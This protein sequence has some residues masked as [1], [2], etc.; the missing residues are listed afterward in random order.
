MMCAI[1]LD[2]EA[3]PFLSDDAGMTAIHWAS[4]AGDAQVLQFLLVRCSEKLT[5]SLLKPIATG[6]PLKEIVAI[7]DS[8]EASAKAF[9]EGGRPGMRQHVLAVTTPLQSHGTKC[10]PWSKYSP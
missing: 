2:V 1:L 9:A 4:Q 7:M 3:N 5:S 10:L 6:E 8:A